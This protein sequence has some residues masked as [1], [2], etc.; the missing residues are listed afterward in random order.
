MRLRRLQLF[1]YRNFH[2][3]DLAVSRNLAV[4]IGENA[5][6]KSNLLE[7]IY[8]LVTMRAVRADTDVQLIRREIW[9]DVQPAA[10][11]VGHIETADGLLKVEVA[12]VARQGANNLIATKSVRV[13][14]S[15]R[16][17]ADAVGRI[18][19]VLFTADDLETVTGSPSPRRRFID[20]ALS[21]VDGE[22]SE[23][24][25]QYEKVVPQRNSLLKRIRE[26]QA[27]RDELEFWDTKLANHGGLIL[28]R[29]AVALERLGHLAAEAHAS[30]AFDEVLDVR[31]RPRVDGMD[32]D[33]FVDQSRSAKT[34]RDCLHLGLN[35]DIAAGMTL[36][37]PH[38]DDIEFILDG[39]SASGFA[40][41]AQQR[42]IA[43]A[44][45]LAEARFLRER[46]EEA[47]LLLLDDILSEMDG[48]RRKSVLG[49][50]AG[51]GQTLVT[52][53]DFDRF[54]AEFTSEGELLRVE[55]GTVAPL[56]A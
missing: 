2:R 53:T 36:N 51:M 18:T 35:R 40:S 1:D 25:R 42:T 7:A 3:L 31:Y 29:R 50:L 26:G 5:Q 27:G 48:G 8:L 12:V 15:A 16:R 28:H 38:R 14:G 11:V 9:S 10:R 47:P 44:L 37:G 13:N 39:A 34:L 54:P 32:A 56:K 23:A 46:R 21:Q 43:L 30:L 22:Y 6:G 20:I 49:A 4:F 17:L 41:R 45:R 33:S 19:A 24:L 55:A 52:G